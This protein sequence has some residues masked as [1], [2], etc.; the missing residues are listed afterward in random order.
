M[1]RVSRAGQARQARELYALARVC[2]HHLQDQARAAHLQ[3]PVSDAVHA[4]VQ[5]WRVLARPRA[6]QR[7]P[8]AS[9]ARPRKS[10]LRKAALLLQLF[11][12]IYGLA[13]VTPYIHA[14]HTYVHELIA[15]H[16]NITLF[17]QQSVEKLNDFTTREY[18]CTN[19]HTTSRLRRRRPPPPS[20]WPRMRKRLSN[21][22]S[23]SSK[24][25]MALNRQQQQQ[26]H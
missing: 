4:R 9:R 6:H 7:H 21:S 18:L 25:P 19:K 22:N 26:Q 13:D 24:R 23:G 10:R 5:R 14:L 12:N 11:V 17:D 3:Q 15:E 8:R 2:A 16:G 20:Q 1:N